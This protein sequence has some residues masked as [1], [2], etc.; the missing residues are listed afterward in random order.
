MPMTPK[1]RSGPEFLDLPPEHYLPE[2]LEGTLADIRWVNR[3]LGDIRAIEK[4][5]SVKVA[6]RTS[7]SLLD[8]ATGTADIPVAIAAWARKRG[9]R[10]EITGMDKN[11]DIIEFARKWSKGYPEIK[12][13]VA[14]GL[15]L[16][17]PAKSFDF[18]ICSK[19]AH[20][21][22]DEE[23]VRLIG[24]ML[25]VARQGYL[26]MD[27]RRSRIASFLIW[28]LTRIFTRNRLTRYDGPMSV[29]RSFSDGELAQLAM[30]AGATDFTI[31]RE[32]FWLLVME[33]EVP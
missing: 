9:I 18:V 17:F 13:V 16:P 10:A 20:H 8:I 33:G 25:R 14:N 1:R 12:L 4:H 28:G 23:V 22:A 30:A 27:L 31:W 7:F 15:A 21:L 3:Y 11:G 5:M 24:E 19:T 6:G 2:E 26:I 32:P 29:L